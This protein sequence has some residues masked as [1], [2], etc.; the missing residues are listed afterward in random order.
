MELWIIIV[1][2]AVLVFFSRFLLL[3][4]WIPLKL[5]DNVQQFLKY[6]APAVLTAIATPIVL[7]RHDTI[8]LTFNN[9]YLLAGLVVIGLAWVTKNILLSVVLG[10]LC[11][12][13]LQYII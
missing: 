1:S 12:W 11:F 7:I 4:P 9:V 5:N 2:V 3:E 8:S 6:S 10:M 13:G